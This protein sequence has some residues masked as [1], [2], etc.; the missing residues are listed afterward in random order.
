MD[1]RITLYL[2]TDDAK[3][4]EAIRVHKDYIVSETLVIEWATAPPG[5]GAYRSE[6]KI[7]GATL[8]IELKKQS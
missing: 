7:E 1:D 3:L 5:E 4:S 6:V 2:H 8:I